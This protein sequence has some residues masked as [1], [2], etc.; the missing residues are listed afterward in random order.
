MQRRLGLCFALLVMFSLLTIGSAQA[1]SKSG[2]WDRFDVDITVNEDGTFWVQEMQVLSFSGGTFT[3]VYRNINMDRLNKIT[4]VQVMGDNELYTESSGGA[5]NTYE[6]STED[7]DRYI[8]WYFAPTEE[9]HTYILRYLVHGGLRYYDD[10]DQLWWKAVPADLI[11][12]VENST[13]TVHLPAGATAEV[14]EAYNVTS[15]ITGKGTRTVT[16]EAQEPIYPGTEYE[17]RVQFPHG[18]VSCWVSSSAT[19]S[20]RSAP[21]RAPKAP[22]RRPR[23][24]ELRRR[25]LSPP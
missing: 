3:Y 23:Q 2:Y 13:V 17:V 4:D 21:K 18:I 22:K 12:R 24:P 16:F 8:K 14:V 11:A 1:Q 19:T 10:G 5:P 9:R 25:K 7:G 15:Q 20:T 6:I